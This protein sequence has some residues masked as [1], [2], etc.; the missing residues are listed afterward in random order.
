MGKAF[1]FAVCVAV[2][3]AYAQAKTIFE[4][5]AMV[6][7]HRLNALSA[8]PNKKGFV[9][10]ESQWSNDTNVKENTVYYVDYSS[11][12]PTM[13]VVGGGVDPKLDFSPILLDDG[14]IMFLSARS[15]STQLFVAPA[16][17]LDNPYQLTDYPV[18]IDTFKVGANILAFT[19][20]LYPG[21][22][23]SG[24]AKID[25][26]RAKRWDTTQE[27]N[28]GFVRRWDAFW[29]GKY[30]HV[31]YTSQLVGDDGTHDAGGE[32]RTEGDAAVTFI[33]EGVHLFAND[34]AAF[35]RSTSKDFGVFHR[36]DDYFLVTIEFAGRS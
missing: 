34:V 18:D 19:A 13:Q 21:T 4:P 14:S 23:M 29:D 17:D 27:W 24:T 8:Q 1:V 36:W 3:A 26:E 7:L 33:K 6:Q 32:F 5:I 31:L 16:D 30:S 2:V 10:G 12:D 15:G 9:F 25:K 22:T 20:M 35:A 28:K 11:E